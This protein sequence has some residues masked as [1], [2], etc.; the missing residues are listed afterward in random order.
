[1]LSGDALSNGRAHENHTE[2]ET[3]AVLSQVQNCEVERELKPWKPDDDASENLTL[4]FNHT[5]RLVS[6]TSL[7]AGKGIS[8]TCLGFKSLVLLKEFA[9]AGGHEVPNLEE[10][11]LT[12]CYPE[13][14]INSKQTRPYLVLKA[15]SMRSF[16]PPS[17]RGDRRHVKGRGRHGGLLVKLRGRPHAMFILQRLSPPSLPKG[18]QLIYVQCF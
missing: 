8:S 16:T 17:L 13:V 6:F 12:L 1:L 10:L 3:D 5:W 18:Q 15:H 2:I 7:N 4:N 14:G 9:P 11:A